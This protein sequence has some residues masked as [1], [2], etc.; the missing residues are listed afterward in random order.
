[1]RN[2]D[3]LMHHNVLCKCYQVHTGKKQ[4]IKLK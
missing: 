3:R 2:F 4:K 1:M